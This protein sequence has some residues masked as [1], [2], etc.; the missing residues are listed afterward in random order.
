MLKAALGFVTTPLGGTIAAALVAALALGAYRL[1]AVNDG[2]N[3]AIATI[4]RANTAA[5]DGADAAEAN[6]EACRA[7]RIWNREKQKCEP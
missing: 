2:W 1:D 4:T 5:R 7:P 6:V 3:K